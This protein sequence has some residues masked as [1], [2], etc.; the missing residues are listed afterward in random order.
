VA[1]EHFDCPKSVSP[2]GGLRVGNNCYFQP[3]NSTVHTIEH[4]FY[5]TVME[6]AMFQHENLGES[7]GINFG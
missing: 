4:R 6:E 1:E 5:K 2:G 7:N 3:R